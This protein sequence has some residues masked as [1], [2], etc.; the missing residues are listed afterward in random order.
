MFRIVGFF[1]V[2][3][4]LWVVLAPEHGKIYTIQVSGRTLHIVIPGK[5]QLLNGIR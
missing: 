1:A 2:V 4:L 5:A 3:G